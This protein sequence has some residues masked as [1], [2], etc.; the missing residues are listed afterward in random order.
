V[1]AIPTSDRYQIN[2]IVDRLVGDDPHF[3][4]DDARELIRL[5]PITKRALL[6]GSILW[7]GRTDRTSG[8]S[9][10]VGNIDQKDTKEAKTMK[11]GDVG[12]RVGGYKIEHRPGS[13]V[14]AL[15][16]AETNPL[17]EGQHARLRYDRATR[18]PIDLQIEVIRTIKFLGIVELGMGD[19]VHWKAPYVP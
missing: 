4:L 5:T 8:Y 6:G 2:A 10:G 9:P 7:P 13:I 12:H 11:F 3:A 16:W 17:K 15:M 1:K 19:F 18:E 14:I